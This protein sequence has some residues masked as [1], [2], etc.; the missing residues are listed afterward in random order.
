M[1]FPSFV[2]EISFAKQALVKFNSLS[3]DQGIETEAPDPGEGPYLD[4]SAI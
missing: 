2:A 1:F 4:L 3:K